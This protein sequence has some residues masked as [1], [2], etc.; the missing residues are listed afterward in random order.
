MRRNDYPVMRHR[1]EVSLMEGNEFLRNRGVVAG[2]VA[3]CLESEEMRS[4]LTYCGKPVEV[5]VGWPIPGMGE[6][7]I[8]LNR[9]VELFT[10]TEGETALYL[11]GHVAGKP[12]AQLSLYYFC[13]FLGS[14]YGSAPELKAIAGQMQD[15]LPYAVP[16]CSAERLEEMLKG[17]KLRVH[18]Y[19]TV[20]AKQHHAGDEA[21]KRVGTELEGIKPALM[22]QASVSKLRG[23]P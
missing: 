9:Q 19:T 14:D 20:L 8:V 11:G 3:S 12:N 18:T 13:L 6:R 22:R 10:V 15:A 1:K 2:L 23:Q 5:E 4:Y 17:L 21:E 7:K 16:N